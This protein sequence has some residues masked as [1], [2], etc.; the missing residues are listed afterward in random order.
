MDMKDLAKIGE[1]YLKN[2]ENLAAK[3]SALY[4]EQ[5]NKWGISEGVYARRRNINVEDAFTADDILFFNPFTNYSLLNNRKQFG[6]FGDCT[7]RIV[8]LTP[9]CAS[10][11]AR[12]IYE[13]FTRPR[14]EEILYPEK[15][16]ISN[17]EGKK[18]SDGRSDSLIGGY[19]PVKKKVVLKSRRQ[20]AKRESDDDDASG[21]SE[22]HPK[23]SAK[24]ISVK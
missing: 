2:H 10:Y 5:K 3:A 6:V 1:L 20:V 8:C 12:V 14:I 23:Q 18:T 4:S 9:D 21:V 22:I 24:Q 11:C 16:K 7:I 13:E 19:T 17:G 15:N